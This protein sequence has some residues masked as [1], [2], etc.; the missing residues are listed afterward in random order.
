MGLG[1]GPEQS[2]QDPTRESAGRSWQFRLVFRNQTFR[3][4]FGQD[5]GSEGEDG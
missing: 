1:A 4:M 5:G 3:A 2:L